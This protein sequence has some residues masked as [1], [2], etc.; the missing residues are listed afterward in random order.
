MPTRVYTI[1]VR[2]DFCFPDWL[3]A[4]QLFYALIQKGKLQEVTGK[5]PEGYC[6]NTGHW[7]FSLFCKLLIHA[8]M[9]IADSMVAMNAGSDHVSSGDLPYIRGQWVGL[10]PPN[11]SACPAS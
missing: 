7:E 8:S 9:A 5:A 4:L 6:W 1:V 3:A 11:S 2:I 10:A